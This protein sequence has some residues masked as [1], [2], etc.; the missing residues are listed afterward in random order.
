MREAERYVDGQEI[1]VGDQV[2]FGGRAATVVV[3][4]G[5]DEYAPDFRP[6][7]W[8]EY[9]RGFLL[10]TVDGHLYM[11]DYADEDIKLLGRGR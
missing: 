7:D 1:H 10:R 5:R 9:E 11:Q 3:V 4:L 2:L 8:T 6:D